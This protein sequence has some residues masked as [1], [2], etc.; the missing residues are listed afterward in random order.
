MV[1]EVLLTIEA[2][3][4]A[5]LVAIE[6]YGITAIAMANVMDL[7]LGTVKSRLRLARDDFQK[8]WSRRQRVQS[9]AG[10][11]VLPLRAD[12]LLACGSM[13]PR[14]PELRRAALWGWFQQIMSSEKETGS[15]SAE[16]EPHPDPEVG[17][18]G[19]AAASTS[20]LGPGNATSL[21]VGAGLGVALVLLIE[22]PGGRPAPPAVITPEALAAACAISTAAPRTSGSV[23]TREPVAVSPLAVRVPPVRSAPTSAATS[24]SPARSVSSADAASATPDDDELAAELAL[25][26]VAQ[27]AFDRGD[28]AAAEM[29]LAQHEQRFARGK[30]ASSRE[31]LRVRLLLREGKRGEATARAEGIRRGLQPD[32]PL[33]RTLDGLLNMEPSR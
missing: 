25:L 6:V 21:L 20:L 33:A 13:I 29:N 12:V 4:R 17:R 15:R 9:R 8:E 19:S 18:L 28:L 27:V 32:S 3:R 24:A 26:R 11:V 2:E 14:L 22:P 16:P 23:A 31:L 1:R 5:V 10:A 30:M 7:P